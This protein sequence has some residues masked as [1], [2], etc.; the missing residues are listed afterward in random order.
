MTT[1]NTRKRTPRR[2]ARPDAPQEPPI[3]VGKR[4]DEAFA[5][6]TERMVD[7]YDLI[8][9]DAT[10]AAES[11]LAAYDALTRTFDAGTPYH[12]LACSIHGC[13]ES[14]VA[15]I[16]H[17]DGREPM[18]LCRLHLADA[19]DGIRRQR[20]YEQ[21]RAVQK[22]LALRFARLDPAVQHALDGR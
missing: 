17:E 21:E 3:D 1:D 4:F 10:H 18:R 11:I 7:T 13:V 16:D 6:A 20:A 8:T 2:T 5:A 15:T 12:L 22:E 14:T 19:L 9:A